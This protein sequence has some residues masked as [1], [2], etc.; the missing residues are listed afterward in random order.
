MDWIDEGWW[1]YW[2]DV[3]CLEKALVEFGCMDWQVECWAVGEEV[4]VGYHESE[5]CHV[6]RH[7]HGRPGNCDG[8]WNDAGRGFIPLEDRK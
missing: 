1:D 6:R 5:A 2:S 7:N 3:G 4:Y 8:W